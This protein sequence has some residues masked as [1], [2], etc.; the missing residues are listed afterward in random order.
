MA[1]YLRARDSLRDSFTEGLNDMG[2][3]ISV[4]DSSLSHDKIPLLEPLPACTDVRSPD[5]SYDKFFDR[6][7]DPATFG[8]KVDQERRK[9]LD[10]QNKPA[11]LIGRR[12]DGEQP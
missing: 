5:F 3:W 1:S 7:R 10:Q 9:L 8:G 12:L 11:G 2:K 4:Q 6:E